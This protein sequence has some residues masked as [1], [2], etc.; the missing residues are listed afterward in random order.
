MALQSLLFR[1]DPKLEGAAVSD[2]AHIF[3]GANGPHVAKIQQALNQL[4]GA[5]LAQD[6]IF[7]PRTAGAVSSFKRGRQILNT[8]GQIDNIVGKKTMA[9]L[10]AEMLAKERGGGVTPPGPKPPSP[11][12]PGPKPPA[13]KPPGP[14]P[15]PP[16][17][18]P[19]DPAPAPTV[20]IVPFT[21]GVP[22]VLIKTFDNRNK[23]DLNSE[24]PPAPPLTFSEKLAI[25]PFKFTPTIVL[26]GLMRSELFTFAQGLGVKM[27]ELFKQN[28]NKD[29]AMLFP[30]QP[31]LAAKVEATA[32][33][34]KAHNAVRKEFE[35]AIKKQFASGKVDVNLLEAKTEGKGLFGRRQMMNPD[36]IKTSLDLAIPFT[37]VNLQAVIG[38]SFQGGQAALKAFSA[39][40]A[41]AT[42]TAT[43]QY[44][45]LDHFGVDNGD[46]VGPL[47]H[48]SPGQIAFWILQH[49]HRPGFMPY[50]TTVI[51]ERAVSG[52]M[53]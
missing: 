16:S 23:S 13:P 30:P 10:D 38:G 17:P 5:G 43:L 14:L 31:L 35:D 4:D 7:G 22:M 45:M 41:T 34:Q 25:L 29:A 53:K 8:Q 19:P 6:G 21:R 12:P 9:T 1:G 42:Y 32:V 40:A 28:T 27:F 15:T 18:L 46:V 11:T 44:I 51:I 36:G 52:S 49:R 3:Q 48:G 50:T 39:N 37:E 2:P 33:F 20:T 26:E 24:D 47:P